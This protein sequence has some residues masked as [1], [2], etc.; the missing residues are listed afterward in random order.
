M[1][2]VVFQLA[3]DQ[4]QTHENRAEYLNLKSRNINRL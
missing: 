3:R 4:R 2:C 1:L